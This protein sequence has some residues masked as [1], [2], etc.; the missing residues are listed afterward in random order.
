MGAR[1]GAVGWGTRYKPK[2][3]G[4]G[5]RWCH[6]SFSLTYPPGLH[7][8]VRSTRHLTEAEYQEYFL[9]AKGGRCV[10]LTTLP[11]YCNLVASTSWNPQGLNT[12]CFSFHHYWILTGWISKDETDTCGTG[13]E[14]GRNLY[15]VFIQVLDRSGTLR[16]L[17]L[18]VCESKT[19]FV[20]YIV[21]MWTLLNTFKVKFKDDI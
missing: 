4:F 1:S 19:A 9:G 12:V 3:R 20:Y 5:S 13:H 8:A 16:G 21:D 10:G 7:M 11:P 14:E 18:M 17:S 15:Q 2:G 6:W